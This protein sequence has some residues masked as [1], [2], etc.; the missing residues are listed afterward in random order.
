MGI[1]GNDVGFTKIVTSIF[2]G[3][4]STEFQ[5]VPE[6]LRQLSIRLEWVNEKFEKIQIPPE[7]IFYFEYFDL[8]RNEFRQFDANCGGLG[9]ATNQ[10]F[11]AADKIVEK[12]INDVI[13]EASKKF[14]W[15]FVKKIEE[16]FSS[17]GICS[18]NSFIRTISESVEIQGNFLGSF[19]P[20]YKGHQAVAN[21]FWPPLRTHFARI[22]EGS[23]KFS[24]LFFSI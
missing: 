12:S 1:G 14:R 5:L 21:V 13:C 19:H 17:H 6:R 9:L 8:L 2:T 23:M 15:N 20:N 3:Q 7:K 18:A 10:D 22:F 24:N 16:I 4:S 11:E